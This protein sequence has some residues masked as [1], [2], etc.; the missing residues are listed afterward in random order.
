MTRLVNSQIWRS[1]PLRLGVTFEAAILCNISQGLSYTWSFVSAE[2][3]TVT[4]PTAV[5]TRRQTIM[6]PSYTLECGNYTAIAKVSSH[7]VPR[8]L[9]SQPILSTSSRENLF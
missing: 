4:L 1:Q 7:T 6:L 9:T 5:N 8:A 2:M 3:T